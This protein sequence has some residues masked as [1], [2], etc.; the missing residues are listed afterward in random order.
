[1]DR[2]GHLKRKYG[3]KLPAVADRLR[4]R[5]VQPLAVDRLCALVQP[6]MEEFF[7]GKETV[8]FQE[9]E[10]EA[11]GFIKKP[12]GVGLDVPVWLESLEDEVRKVQSHM[13][14]D[15]DLPDPFPEIS[16]ASLPLEEVRRQ[17]DTWEEEQAS[18]DNLLP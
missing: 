4:E 9:M 5:F 8:L 2:Y 16:Q 12:G 18:M 14:T 17:L 7:G 13:P 15:S 11:E 3:M 6:A 1:M 10:K